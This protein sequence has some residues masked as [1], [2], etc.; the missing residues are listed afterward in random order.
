MQ[1]AQ[2]Q[3]R[4]GLAEVEAVGEL[5]IAEDGVRIAHVRTD[6]DHAVPLGQQGVVVRHH[7][8]IMVDVDDASVWEDVAG[9]LVHA[10]RRGQAAAQVEVLRDAL[11]GEE[12]HR[13][14]EEAAVGQGQPSRVEPGL[15]QRLGRGAVDG[16]IVLAE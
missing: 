4:D 11:L 2:Q 8:R 14:E 9:D 6:G 7:H 12:A 16:E 5:V 1:H 10:R 13:T 3:H 15:H